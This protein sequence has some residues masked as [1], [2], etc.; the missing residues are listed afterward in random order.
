MAGGLGAW[1]R[2]CWESRLSCCRR[3]THTPGLAPAVLWG[4]LTR[5]RCHLRSEP[6]P[7]PGQGSSLT[8][9][10]L[11]SAE[12]DQ[13]LLKKLNVLD[14]RLSPG[15]LED[16]LLAEVLRVER[17]EILKHRQA[18]QLGVLQL[19]GKLEATEVRPGWVA[20]GPVGLLQAEGPASQPASPPSA[21]SPL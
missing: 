11:A 12:L 1:S 5:G 4:T 18:L 3:T 10:S 8:C 20:V 9:S 6:P 19:E 16:L 7:L 14:L 17:R 21:N 15:A 2:H 13:A